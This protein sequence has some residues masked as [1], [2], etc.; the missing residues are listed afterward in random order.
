MSKKRK[1]IT[2]A[3]RE[4]WIKDWN[5]SLEQEYKPYIN[6]RDIASLGNKHRVVGSKTDGREAQ[7]LSTNEYFMF[8]QLEFDPSVISIKEQ[9]LLPL[10]LTTQIAKALEVKHPIYTRTKG[11]IKAPLTSDFLT[12]RVN[13]R[14]KIISVKDSRDADKSRTKEKQMIEQAAWEVQGEDWE[15]V[16]DTQLK[17]NFSRNLELLFP[18]RILKPVNYYQ[19]LFV[20]WLPNFIAYIS[21]TPNCPLAD[22]V[23]RSAINVGMTFDMARD[24]FF[25]AIWHRH[26]SFDF[27][28]ILGLELSASELNLIPND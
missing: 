11:K 5:K 23:D 26:L 2:L 22:V 14:N 27:N 21:D 7:L 8:L 17:N 24:L 19:K 4:R 6:T 20:K 18:F 25:H 10:D 1:G 9:Y 3:D 28:Q 16:L 15:Q 13:N 12:T